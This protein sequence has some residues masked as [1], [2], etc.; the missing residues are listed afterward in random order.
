MKALIHVNEYKKFLQRFYHIDKPIEYY[1][2]TME[3][4]SKWC[5]KLYEQRKIETET[6]RIATVMI[7]D[8]MH[9]RNWSTRDIDYLVNDDDFFSH[10][11]QEDEN[12]DLPF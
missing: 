9:S 7:A 5:K 1:I 3:E 4:Y 6:A 2:Q 10:F 11:P 8:Y 12:D